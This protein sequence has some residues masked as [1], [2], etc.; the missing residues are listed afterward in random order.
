[1]GAAAD[2]RTPMTTRTLL[3]ALI[4]SGS[5]GGCADRNPGTV[6]EILDPNQMS[7]S[8]LVQYAR[9]N[10]SQASARNKLQANSAW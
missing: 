10:A 4:L 2:G 1:M 3:A 7:A 8:L 6:D 5:L 9:L